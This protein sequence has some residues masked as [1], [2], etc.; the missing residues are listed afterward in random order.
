MAVFVPA[1]LMVGFT[2]LEINLM[3]VALG[4]ELTTEIS[5]PVDFVVVVTTPSGV[6]S[7]EETRPDPTTRPMERPP[8]GSAT[9][10]TADTACLATGAKSLTFQISIMNSSS[11]SYLGVGFTARQSNERVDE[12]T[13]SFARLYRS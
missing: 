11:I 10:T 4:G 6:D 9:V 1:K 2:T 8:T 7:C 12:A 13:A 5:I 3:A